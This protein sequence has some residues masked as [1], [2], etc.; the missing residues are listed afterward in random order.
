M[1]G[2]QLIQLAGDE[3]NKKVKRAFI[4]LYIIMVKQPEVLLT[5]QDFLM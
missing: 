1:E 3:A 4:M 2:I 5:K